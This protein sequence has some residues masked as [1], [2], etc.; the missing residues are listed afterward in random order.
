MPK[1]TVNGFENAE[2]AKPEATPS[3]YELIVIDMPYALLKRTYNAAH[4]ELSNYFG[5][6]L[7][8]MLRHF[9]LAIAQRSM[10]RGSRNGLEQ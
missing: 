4:S 10:R 1:S 2:I 9:D 5:I 3:M 8:K 7:R 6:W